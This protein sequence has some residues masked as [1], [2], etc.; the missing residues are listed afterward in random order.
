[1]NY[2]SARHVEAPEGDLRRGSEGLTEAATYNTSVR[3]RQIVAE[4]SK[5]DAARPN[6]ERELAGE[7]G[8]AMRER[9]AREAKET[10]Q[11]KLRRR[12]ERAAVDALKKKL[13][14]ECGFSEDT[15]E[16]RAREIQSRRK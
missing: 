2:S 16:I 12:T 5:P 6:T 15:A 7:A 10:E 9:W 13:I 8:L 14:D 11:V 3:G 4:V 1:M